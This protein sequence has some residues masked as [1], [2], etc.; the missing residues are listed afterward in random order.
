MKFLPWPRQLFDQL[1]GYFFG[2]KMDSKLIYL[3]SPYWHES[4]WMRKG[5]VELVQQKTAELLY[6]GYVIY[7]P[8]AHNAELARYLPPSIRNS[9]GFWLGLDLVILRRCDELWVLTLLEWKLSRG[10]LCEIEEAKKLSLP[11]RYISMEV[12]LEPANRRNRN[13]PNKAAP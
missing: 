5:R 4:A 8:I 11:I 3:A 7:S 1:P 2:E 12:P 6:Q 13:Q 9:H 10:V